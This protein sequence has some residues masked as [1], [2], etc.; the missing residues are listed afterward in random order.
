MVA[1]VSQISAAHRFGAILPCVQH[2]ARNFRYGN[3]LALC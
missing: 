3:N 2:R 1:A